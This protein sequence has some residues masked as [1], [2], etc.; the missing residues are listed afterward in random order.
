[1]RWKIRDRRFDRRMYEANE[2]LGLE[3][4]IS[5]LRLL[6]LVMFEGG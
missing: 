2:S 5:G 3:L 6:S 4:V 1:M